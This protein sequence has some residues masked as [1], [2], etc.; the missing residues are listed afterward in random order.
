[1]LPWQI[2]GRHNLNM[3]IFIDYKM[4]IKLN[5]SYLMTEVE[6]VQKCLTPAYRLVLLTGR[7]DGTLSTLLL[8]MIF[9]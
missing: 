8:G 4:K 2:S 6:E 7:R 5:I 1:M 3:D 9:L